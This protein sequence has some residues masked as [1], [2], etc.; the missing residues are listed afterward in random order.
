MLTP[1]E[2]EILMARSWQNSYPSVLSQA[3][4]ELEKLPAEDEITTNELVELLFP[5]ASARGAGID[6]R[7]KVYKALRAAQKHGGMEGYWHPGPARRYMGHNINPP[8]WHRFNQD[9]VKGIQIECPCCG[10]KFVPGN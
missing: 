6:A 2:W 7:K 4:A 9:H 8:V 10:T 3:R 5:E 1:A